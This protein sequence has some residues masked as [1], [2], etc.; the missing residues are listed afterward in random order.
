[1][2]SNIGIM[3][4]VFFSASTDGDICRNG[5]WITKI[6]GSRYRVQSEDQDLP[7]PS[8]WN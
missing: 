8:L 5:G 2:K 3:K 1:M 7:S 6:V 4:V